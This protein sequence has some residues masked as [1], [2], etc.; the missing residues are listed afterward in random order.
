[1]LTMHK[2]FL[3]HCLR[4][5]PSTQYVQIKRSFFSRG[6]NRFPLDDVIEAMKGVYSS[7][8]LSQPIGSTGTST[9]LACNVDVSNGTFWV[10]QALDQAARNY[11]S[12]RNR[13]SKSYATS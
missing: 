5:Y 12:A 2:D 7:I 4:Q 1:M 9:G 3:D 13:N 11:C 6:D 10:T 8:R